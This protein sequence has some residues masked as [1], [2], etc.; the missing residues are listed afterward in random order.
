M[1]SS[2]LIRD[3]KAIGCE[4]VHHKGTSHQK[5]Y[6]P[7]TGKRFTVPHPKKHLPIGTLKSIKKSAGLL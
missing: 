1:R 2:D 5:W 6:S 7:V 3:L 4:L